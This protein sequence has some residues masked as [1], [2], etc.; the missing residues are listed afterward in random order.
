MYGMR[1][2]ARREKDRMKKKARFILLIVILA[3]TAGITVYLVSF[4]FLPM[5][6][7]RKA[8]A[9][10]RENQFDEAAEGFAAISRKYD[11]G[12]RLAVLGGFA[13]AAER[14]PE[15][16][17]E[18]GSYLREQGDYEGAVAAYEELG[19]YK[20]SPDQVKNTRL[21]EAD[22]RISE[23]DF[24]TAISLLTELGEHDGGSFGKAEELLDKACYIRAVRL[25]AI[26]KLE[27]AET[28]FAQTE[29]YQDSYERLRE[30]RY[31][32]ARNA[33]LIYDFE[34]A[35]TLFA[36]V[37]DY[38]DAKELLA[39][40]DTAVD[41]VYRSPYT[42]ITGKK[43]NA[44]VSYLW[45]HSV[46]VPG[47]LDEGISVKLQ[48][49]RCVGDLNPAWF[50]AA[51]YDYSLEQVRDA[52]TWYFTYYGSETENEDGAVL[53]EAQFSPDYSNLTTR[54]VYKTTRDEEMIR[55][56]QRA[57]EEAAKVAEAED[58]ASD[59][60]FSQEEEGD[61]E[62]EDQ[63]EEVALPK[64]ALE[65]TRHWTSV[66]DEE[67]LAAIK[68]GFRRR[69]RVQLAEKG[70]MAFY[71]DT[72]DERLPHYCSVSNCLN[73]GTKVAS[74]SNGRRYYCEEHENEYE[75]DPACE[76]D[77]NSQ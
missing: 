31:N 59:Q 71:N 56:A 16:R 76:A 64:P 41:R 39:I 46:I 69:L 50:G 36:K 48:E 45:M 7:Y 3:L 22:A 5:R 37:G 21:A 13:D 68:E 23:N 55:D 26:G 63:E 61:E 70:N 74:D 44:V 28:G 27:D 8:E 75:K 60:E 10:A 32:M 30:V 47:R 35:K 51:S 66:G 9:L 54:K 17:Y 49:D 43:T 65:G 12:G 19:D 6:D 73:K 77:N 38:K 14:V 57:E 40:L 33:L 53:L 29:E 2:K 52:D 20:D 72:D 58:D 1:A 67:K 62:K 15:M 18:K 25:E 24:E 34:T 4:L 42:D 11:L